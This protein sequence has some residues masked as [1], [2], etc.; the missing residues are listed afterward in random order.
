[1]TV[2]ILLLGVGFLT[3]GTYMIVR[4]PRGVGQPERFGDNAAVVARSIGTLVGLI[5]LWLIIMALI[6]WPK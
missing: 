2:T 5:G 4:G 6:G 3:V 1:V